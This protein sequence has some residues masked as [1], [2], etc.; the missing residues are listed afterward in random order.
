MRRELILAP[1]SFRPAEILALWGVQPE[2]AQ[3]AEIGGVRYF[4]VVV[5]DTVTDQQIADLETILAS[6][7]PS[8]SDSERASTLVDLLA[9]GM[10]ALQTILDS[11]DIP[12]GT[13]T[14]AQLSNDVRALQ[15]AIKA[16]ARVLRRV[17]RL[18]RADFNGTD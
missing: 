1:T 12:A 5:A 13:R 15:Q 17:L 10:T 14:T 3:V 7:Q 9:Q 18:I 11:T 4:E 8:P 6:H 2:F 16:E